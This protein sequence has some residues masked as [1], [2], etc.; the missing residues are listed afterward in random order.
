[1][2]TEQNEALVRRFY[3]ELWNCW[4]LSVAEEILS[5]TVEFRG[6][7]GK[8]ADGV[9]AFKAYVEAVRRAFPDWRNRIDE[10]VAAGDRVA[11]RM[12]WTGTHRG[13]LDDLAPTGLR[14]EYCGAAFFHLEAGVI[15]RAW[16]VGDTDALWRTL[17]GAG[18]S[19]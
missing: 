2:P 1:M 4:Q 3:D 7:L 13:P 11:T 6:S 18:G 5:P 14:V 17:R 9:D 12:T 10:I 15:E 19:A 16:V 8:E